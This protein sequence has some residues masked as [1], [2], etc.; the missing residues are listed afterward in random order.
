MITSDPKNKLPETVAQVHHGASQTHL[1]QQKQGITGSLFKDG[2]GA[3]VHLDPLDPNRQP[4]YMIGFQGALQRKW[5]RRCEV[6]KILS[7]PSNKGAEATW[8]KLNEPQT[9]SRSFTRALESSRSLWSYD[10]HSISQACHGSSL[11]TLI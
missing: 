4:L 9:S 1:L 3:Q 10:L 2:F 11:T 6:Q 5:V 8:M 7:M